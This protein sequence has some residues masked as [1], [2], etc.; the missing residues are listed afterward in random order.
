MIYLATELLSSK[1]SYSSVCI[2]VRQTCQRLAAPK[3]ATVVNL[4]ESAC[5]VTEIAISVS[6]VLFSLLLTDRWEFLGLVS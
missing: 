6:I 4:E 2:F 5:S 3:E 1:K